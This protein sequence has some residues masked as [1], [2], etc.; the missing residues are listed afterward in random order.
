[1]KPV[2][3]TEN[4]F[5]DFIAKNGLI[6]CDFWADWCQPCRAQGEI[7]EKSGDELLK[8]F[9]GLKIAKINSDESPNLCER[10]QI[11]GIPQLIGIYKQKIGI[12]R[13]GLHKLPDIAKALTKLMDI[14]AKST[15]KSDNVVLD[16]N[17]IPIKEITADNGELFI[18][19]NPLTAILFW[20]EKW[21]PNLILYQILQEQGHQLAGALPDMKFGQCKCDASHPLAKKWGI[22]GFPQVIVSIN[23]KINYL[24]TGFIQLEDIYRFVKIYEKEKKFMDLRPKKYLNIVEATE[25]TIDDLIAKNELVFISP[26]T[27]NSRESIRQLISLQ[28]EQEVLME[29]FPNLVFVPMQISNDESEKSSKKSTTQSAVSRFNPA[30]Q[31]VVYYKGYYGLMLEGDQTVDAVIEFIKKLIEIYNTDKNKESKLGKEP[32]LVDKEFFPRI[33]ES[34]LNEFLAKNDAVLVDFWASWCTPC[35][36]QGKILRDSWD[37]FKKSFPT[38]IIAKINTDENRKLSK[39]LNLNAI[40]QLTVFY[41]GTI[42]FMEAGLHELEDISAFIKKVEDYYPKSNKKGILIDERKKPDE[43]DHD[44]D[45]NCEECED[46]HE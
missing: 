31:N 45:C 28:I 17:H 36:K 33:S 43:P 7:I 9:P 3:I 37:A 22:Q 12:F 18:K 24:P 25:K 29:A 6:L 46:E 20:N 26:W 15:N 8:Q 32:L 42:S 39:E 44:D 14:V 11:N 40:P 10:F 5:E 16:E 34:E 35:K 38:W 21:L 41:K 23:G 2:E 30:P 13:A 27:P 4:E 19:D 1:M